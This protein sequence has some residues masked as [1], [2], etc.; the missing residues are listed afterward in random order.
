MLDEVDE[1]EWLIPALRANFMA[2]RVM[3]CIT[4]MMF[5][6]SC[7]WRS[8][9][10]WRT[11]CHLAQ[12][13]LFHFVDFWWQVNF[14]GDVDHHDSQGDSNDNKKNYFSYRL[15][16]FFHAQ[17]FN[18]QVPE[19]STYYRHITTKIHKMTLKCMR[20]KLKNMICFW[21]INAIGVSQSSW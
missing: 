5:R 12:T 16:H 8:S 1:M 9:T 18:H 19:T 11:V 7:W 2:C 14:L 20:I 4:I 6:P 3:I 13:C 17:A 15:W 10:G 21:V